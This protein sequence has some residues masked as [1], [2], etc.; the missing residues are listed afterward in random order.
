MNHIARSTPNEV[1]LDGRERGV[2][3]L[4]ISADTARSN[5]NVVL[6]LSDLTDPVRAQ[7][8]VAR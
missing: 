6:C 5:V 4:A 3:P 8:M 1:A 2:Q 7:S